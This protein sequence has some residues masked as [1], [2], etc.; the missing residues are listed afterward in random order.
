MLFNS[1]TF[2]V[3][4]T[5]VV[6]LFYT[7]AHKYRW[8]LLLVASCVFY[9]AF[10]PEYLLILFAII[11]VD[12]YAA[13]MMS[14]V[15]GKK[16]KRYL[17]FSIS[18]TCILL[19]T[20]KYFNF[21]S[22]NIH[23]LSVFL[24]WNYD[25]VL[26]EWVLPI[27]LSFHTFQSLSYVIEV[28]WGRQKP[29]THLGIYATYVMFFPQLVAGPIERP[30]NLLPQFRVHKKPDYDNISR[31]FRQALYGYFKK[32]VIA[33]NLALYVDQ[34]FGN[35]EQ[36]SGNMSMLA[37][38]LFAIQVYCDFSAYSDIA[39]GVARI[40][41]F[42]LMDNFRQPYFS[43]SVP[44]FW[45]RWHI[46]LSTWF[47]DY[48]Y[49]PMGG[50]KVGRWRWYYNLFV[51]FLL[52]GIWHGAGWTYVLFGAIHAFYIIGYYVLRPYFERLSY[53]I[54]LS[55]I[56]WLKNA[57]AMLITFQLIALSFVVFRASDMQNAWDVISN[58]SFHAST[59]M[60]DFDALSASILDVN[61]MRPTLP[62]LIISVVVFLFM[63][64]ML[65][66]ANGRE[67]INNTPKVY[68]FAGYYFMIIWIL[69]FGVYETTPHFVYF[70]F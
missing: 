45:R 4:F 1:I 7:L 16:R 23:N 38:Y 37:M 55:K 57:M 48:V 61:P 41:G 30:Q 50:N 22:E 68:R 47:R 3:F 18:A 46:S 29:E 39:I 10:I 43:K 26:L 51:V 34:V 12:Y 40:M 32:M 8:L 27:G 70:Q 66:F 36:Y 60:A 65:G 49:I 59:F 58:M 63:E 44:E 28:Y 13:R 24:G 56:N 6:L 5:V 19:V 31:G 35:P 14:K 54:G 20:F 67:K 11:L 53:G 62:F 9:G 69:L 33:D 2:L 15:Q 17:W 64:I 25:I 21:A 52:S 42:K